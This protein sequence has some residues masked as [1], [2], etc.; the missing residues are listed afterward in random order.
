MDF[1]KFPR[2]RHIEGSRHQMGD[3]ENDKP[4]SE[5]VGRHLV[6]TEKIDGANCGLS[7]DTAGNLLLQSRGQYLSGGARE[8]HFDLLKTWAFAHSDRL[9]AT[10]GQRYVMFGEWLYAKHTVYYDRLPHYFL[11]FDV[12]DRKTA[13]FLSTLARRQLLGGL[14]IMPVPL[15]HEGHLASPGDLQGLLGTS[16]FKSTVWWNS[17][18]EEAARSGNRAE[19]VERQTEKS[20]LAEG[21]Y[22][23]LEH[24]GYAQERFKFVRGDFLQAIEAADG[25]WLDRPILPNRLLDHV[26]IFAERLGL[27]GAYDELSH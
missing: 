23:K 18:M 24:G 9:R 11:E 20:D 15:L 13:R 10:L 17:L 5:L 4:I 6:V 19:F 2:T 12:Y 21:L 3:L 14:P 1:Q 25:H 16:G 27:P 7:F 26:D 22:V 8:K